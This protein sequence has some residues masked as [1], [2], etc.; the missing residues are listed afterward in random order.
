[1]SRVNTLTSQGKRNISILNI[2]NPFTILIET[3]KASE[4]NCPTLPTSR[5]LSVSPFINI[6]VSIL[7]QYILKLQYVTQTTHKLIQSVIIGSQRSSQETHPSTRYGVC[8]GDN[9][10]K[11]YNPLISNDIKLYIIYIIGHSYIMK[12]LVTTVSNGLDC[13][14]NMTQHVWGIITHV[15]KLSNIINGLCARGIGVGDR[16]VRGMVFLTTLRTPVYFL[17]K[18]NVK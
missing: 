5:P 15:L 10:L 8:Y 14:V 4:V 16:G 9:R 11:W 6:V 12:R 13:V 1:M 17:T 3:N 18:V 2:S 7:Y